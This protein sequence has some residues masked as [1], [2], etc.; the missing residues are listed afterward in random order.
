MKKQLSVLLV[1]SL[2]MVLLSFSVISFGGGQIET[3][4]YSSFDED[5]RNQQQ[6]CYNF[7]DY[8]ENIDTYNISIYNYSNNDFVV[9]SNQNDYN[10][11][12][13]QPYDDIFLDTRDG[14]CGSGSIGIRFI[15]YEINITNFDFLINLTTEYNNE[16]HN[17]EFRVVL[18]NE[19]FQIKPLEDLRIPNTQDIEY[20]EI[21]YKLE[22]YF[23]NIDFYNLEV[24]DLE[25]NYITS[26]TKGDVINLESGVIDTRTDIQPDNKKGFRYIEHDEEEEF[27]YIIG[28]DVMGFDNN[29]LAPDTFIFEL[30]QEIIYGCTDPTALNYDPNAGVDDG[31]CEFEP[32]YNIS[33]CPEFLNIVNHSTNHLGHKYQDLY[34][35]NDIDCSGYT[36][37]G[38]LGIFIGS[39]DGRGY[40]ISNLVLINS[41]GIFDVIEYN[42]TDYGVVSNLGLI[43]ITSTNP[44][45]ISGVGSGIL[46]GQN[47]G[48]INNVFIKDS[49][50]SGSDYTLGL[51]AGFNTV[52]SGGP[53]TISN[54]YV[55]NSSFEGTGGERH[56]GILGQN[57]GV[58][59]NAYYDGYFDTTAPDS[60]CVEAVSNGFNINNVFYNNEKCNYGGNGV[61]LSTVEMT[62]PNNLNFMSSLLE[63]HEWTVNNSYPYLLIEDFV[64]HN[65]FVAND[66]DIVFIDE[67]NNEFQE[68]MTFNGEYWTYFI[69]DTFRF[70]DFFFT[71]ETFESDTLKFTV[72]DTVLIGGCNNPLA[73]NYDE[74]VDFDDGSCE[75]SNYNWTFRI[76]TTETN[77]TF[78]F[79][80][81]NTFMNVD[82]G[83][84]YNNTYYHYEDYNWSSGIPDPL[85]YIEHNYSVPGIYDITLTGG[86][87]IISFCGNVYHEVE[88]GVVKFLCSGS[89]ELFRDV[90]TQIPVEFG[91]KSAHNMFYTM[92]QNHTDFSN[93]PDNFFDLASSNVVDYSRMFENTLF[94]KDISSWNTSNAEY[95][96]GMFADTPFNQDISIW[97]TSNVENMASMFEST[98]F[99]QDISSWDVSQVTVFRNMFRN[100]D[101]N[102][103][104]GDWNVSS[105][106][107]MQSMFR[108]SD[109]NQPI[110][111]WDVSQVTLFNSMFRNSDFNQPIGDWDVSNAQRMSWMF[112]NT[113]FNQD[114]SSWNTSNVIEM[115]G[116]FRGANS[117]N[118]NL[119]NWNFENIGGVS[120]ASSLNLN[121]FLLETNM[122]VEN[123]GA[124][125]TSLANQNLKSGRTITTS[126][127]YSINSK[128]D[129]QF[130]IDNYDWIIQDDGILVPMSVNIAKN[131]SDTNVLN[132]GEV[133]P[134]EL[135]INCIGDYCFDDFQ[136][137]SYLESLYNGFLTPSNPVLVQGTTFSGDIQ[138]MFDEDNST[139][140]E[141]YTTSGN[142]IIMLDYEETILFDDV[143]LYFT[144]QSF[145]GTW[146]GFFLEYYDSNIDDWVIFHE[147]PNLLVSELLTIPLGVETDKIRINFDTD[148]DSVFMRI[149][150]GVGETLVSETIPENTGS[151]LSINNSNPNNLS[152]LSE[153]K[154]YNTGI[155]LEQDGE[156]TVSHEVIWNDNVVGSSD[157]YI[158]RTS[159]QGCT[160][161]KAY[162]YNI[163]ADIDD[164][165]CI[166]YPVVTSVQTFPN[167]V[168]PQNTLYGTCVIEDE[169]EII[170]YHYSWYKNGVLETSGFE[171]LESGE[172]LTN[173]YGESLIIGDEFIFSCHGQNSEN[174]SEVV[175][176]TVKTILPNQLPTVYA[177]HSPLSVDSG[178]CGDGICSI[179]DYIAGTCPTD[180][181]PPRYDAD[182]LSFYCLATD[183]NDDDVMFDWRVYKNGIVY[184]DGFTDYYPQG[185]NI[186]VA[187]IPSED[188]LEGDEFYVSCRADDSF[189]QTDWYDSIVVEVLRDERP[190]SIAYNRI[191]PIIMFDDSVVSV[192]GRAN[193]PNVADVLTYNYSLIVNDVV[194]E[195]KINSSV[196]GVETEAVFD[197]DTLNIGDE[198][199]VL[200]NVTDGEFFVDSTS[201]TVVVRETNTPPVAEARF[202]PTTVGEET[203][204][205][206]YCKGTDP[207]GDRVW[208]NLQ[209]FVNNVSKINTNFLS[210]SSHLYNGFV[211]GTERNRLL[212]S[213]NYE[214][215]DVIRA[216]CTADDS[217][218]SSQN[219]ILTTVV[220]EFN[221]PPTVPFVQIQ[222]STGNTLQDFNFN[223]TMR[224]IDDEEL[225]VSWRIRRNNLINDTQ[226]TDWVSLDGEI[227]K[228]FI[229]STLPASQTK[230][231][232]TYLIEVRAYDGTSYSNWMSSNT[233]TIQNTPPVM[234]SSH[235]ISTFYENETV[236]S[237]CT[238]SDVDTDQDISFNKRWYRN[239][240]LMT[241]TDSL[242]NLLT[243]ADEEWVVSCRAYD[244]YDYSEW[245]NSSS[246]NIIGTSTEP[247]LEYNSLE[248]NTTHIISGCSV[249]DIEGKDIDYAFEL[250]RNG[251]LET[252]V[253][254][255]GES[256]GVNQTFEYETSIVSGENWTFYCEGT[257]PDGVVSDTVN[258]TIPSIDF[259]VSLTSSTET[260]L[261]YD[262]DSNVDEVRLYKDGVFV[263]TTNLD[264][265]TLSGLTPDTSYNISFVPI[266]EGFEGEEVVLTSTTQTTT[267]SPPVM[268]STRISPTTPYTN[269]VL[270]GYCEASDT[271]T[272]RIR[273]L[274][275]WTVDGDVVQAGI[276]GQH[277]RNEEILV[278]SL[279]SHNYIAF[280]NVT[281]S[282]VAHDSVSYSDSLN[283]SISILNKEQEITEVF[284]TLDEEEDRFF[285]DYEFFDIDGDLEI[286]NSF[287]WFIN[288]VLFSNDSYLSVDNVSTS[289]KLVCEVTSNTDYHTVITNSSSY[290]V[291]DFE[292]PVISDVVIPQRTYIDSSTQISAVCEDN[293]GVAKGYP[294]I[295]FVNPNLLEEEYPIFYD[296]GDSFSRFLTFSTAGT[297][298]NI[299]VI[300][301]DGNRNMAV[302]THDSDLNSRARDTNP[303]GTPPS[304]DDDDDVD[305]FDLSL[306]VDNLML[307]FG[308]TR[309]VEFEVINLVEQDLL[310]TMSI[311]VDEDTPETYEWM[312]FEGGFKAIEFDIIRRGSLSSGTKFIRYYV[313][314]PRDV[315]PGEY[316]GTIEFNTEDQTEQ[317]RVRIVVSETGFTLMSVLNYELFKLPFISTPTGAVVGGVAES[318][319]FGFKVWMMMITLSVLGF[320][321]YG[322][323]RIKG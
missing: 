83:D 301:M 45:A 203:N 280:D 174:V 60:G 183:T 102:Q 125:L 322:Y 55:L 119:S 111:D 23:I 39:F 281:L 283:T 303:P 234:L 129:R 232:E 74:T 315:E 77:Q 87:E 22:D 135:E 104:I 229:L 11:H 247:Y 250:F 112:E 175:N 267:N 231:G 32:V 132:V 206:V 8:Y 161:P 103:P 204:V 153:P 27:E 46:T 134:I 227:E 92:S 299:E 275:E 100:S 1:I 284:V 194:V 76:E 97:N 243:S 117:F 321:V 85:L 277:F 106:T 42:G 99:N 140:W 312:S 261:R 167:I 37:E 170:T 179:D 209:V 224:D 258:L 233:I 160:D 48:K 158:I 191:F 12:L 124:L 154:L 30:Y 286:N 53:G 249:M 254:R 293:I 180:C 189:N 41:P 318:E 15:E 239:G 282:C 66:Y 62:Y 136:I 79:G 72:E 223:V 208:L 130:I 131:V 9:F 176:S 31:S 57:N 319:M 122:S 126:S 65:I 150:G 51:F 155:K 25:W 185:T 195:S 142:V 171:V 219:E 172:E 168:S 110:G 240:E 288:D 272:S 256:P 213:V 13:P 242:S 91:L 68:N 75:V 198:V 257:N 230:A 137:Y 316:F 218:D 236:F 269:N 95:F 115:R 148:D 248:A 192:Q 152:N 38:S 143:K 52:D 120:L 96:L 105:V 78:K 93:T 178:Y 202:L 274:Y 228:N 253:D 323:R 156:Y 309:I 21:F 7:L 238:A 285:C 113:P 302:Y 207:D 260:S 81:Y 237:E 295:R 35:T 118:Q 211:S 16:I 73:G 259:S 193:D 217:V 164:G 145:G 64:P 246:F 149:F 310:F 169:E 268:V 84:G 82:F 34:L 71:T 311:I 222:P 177:K 90:L 147:E 40:S 287:R 265:Y 262:W 314:V 144:H 98:P 292:P 305:Y 14:F 59:K 4:Y 151:F 116:M 196:Q 320:G 5:L 61:G 252:S 245:L 2:M 215:G 49:S 308:Q 67:K 58:L 123:Y 17:Q 184:D 47:D 201:N 304:D 294:K 205:R 36:L 276:T 28:I 271:D 255:L 26:G 298:T 297:Y 56:G 197:Y 216:V 3:R 146:N 70:K 173:N 186:H 54:I 291:G 20:Q 200:M 157:T 235:L 127:Q 212:S 317:Y 214:V 263:L 190:P 6:L 128:D 241:T 133:L 221:Y 289:D 181:N 306:F 296:S 44:M 313:N 225:Q 29:W 251:V 266:K 86:A 50:I 109:F 138:N 220:E 159:I 210:S 19:S 273:F 307:S 63:L 114:I 290:F 121:D 166:Y 264:R 88:E 226:T 10:G 107:N 279:A 244:G 141:V 199:K 80:T 300:C 270:S 18:T 24:Y 162:N 33:S 163:D 89:S 69:N 101:F 278:D 182:N 94:N 43:N 187:E 188:I 165:S 139:H 108:N